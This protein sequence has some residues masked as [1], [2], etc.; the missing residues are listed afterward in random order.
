MLQFRIYKHFQIFCQYPEMCMVS[1]QLAA[2]LVN[3]VRFQLVSQGFFSRWRREGCIQFKVYTVCLFGAVFFS[4]YP[5]M[6]SPHLPFLSACRAYFLPRS[7]TRDVH[8]FRSWEWKFMLGWLEQISFYCKCVGLYLEGGKKK[9]LLGG[10]ET[11]FVGS[12]SSLLSPR[13]IPQPRCRDSS[14]ASSR[15]ARWASAGT[16]SSRGDFIRGSHSISRRRD[17]SFR[18]WVISA[19]MM[20]LCFVFK[21]LY[22][23]ERNHLH[24]QRNPTLN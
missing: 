19:W 14:T 3:S 24:V 12:L 20:I 9:R 10:I 23:N 5:F 2:S 13:S 16:P 11:R 17:S 7:P 18:I 8:G 15:S 6:L 22:C 4:C 1:I 21:T